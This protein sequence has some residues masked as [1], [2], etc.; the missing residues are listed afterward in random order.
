M[1]Q[2]M[3]LQR[4]GHDLVTEQQQQQWLL[5]NVVLVTMLCGKVNQ[6]CVYIYPLLFGFSSHLGH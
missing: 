6:L 2:S 5:Y 4:V 1:L 3:G